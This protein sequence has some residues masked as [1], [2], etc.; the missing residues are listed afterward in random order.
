MAEKR[1]VNEGKY[2]MQ[3]GEWYCSA[4]GEHCADVITTALNELIT[5]NQKIKNQLKQLQ[6]I[7]LLQN[8]ELHT[9]LEENT[10]LRKTN[11]ELLEK[12]ED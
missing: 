10:I 12:M 6:S 1:F 11:R 7:S 4:A 9:L 5:E 2:I 8:N 3:N